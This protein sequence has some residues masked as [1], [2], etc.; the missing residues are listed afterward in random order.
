MQED[1][2]INK[3]KAYGRQGKAPNRRKM[4]LY[5]YSRGWL[6]FVLLS[7]T[8][9]SYT[10]YVEIG[11]RSERKSAVIIIIIFFIFDKFIVNLAFS[12]GCCT[13]LLCPYAF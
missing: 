11:S 13:V 6:A 4:I 1:T 7:L 2:R 8:N 10:V 12:K 9:Y 3:W 5:H